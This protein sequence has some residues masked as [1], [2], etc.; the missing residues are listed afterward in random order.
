MNITL[1]RIGDIATSLISCPFCGYH[2][3]VAAGYQFGKVHCSNDDCKIFN[4]YFYP[5]Q[6]S[7]R[8]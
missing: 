7:K 5:D 8:T 3:I 6:W 1:D 2:P 4:V